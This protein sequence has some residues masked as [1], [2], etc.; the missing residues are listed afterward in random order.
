MR[1]YTPWG[2]G[3]GGGGL[4][5]IRCFQVASVGHKRPKINY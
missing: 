4:G 2:G 5:V 3:G 1:G